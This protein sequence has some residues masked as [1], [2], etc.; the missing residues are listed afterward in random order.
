MGREV[1]AKVDVDSDSFDCLGARLPRDGWRDRIAG[2]YPAQERP[3]DDPTAGKE[4]QT[5]GGPRVL[6]RRARSKVGS[7]LADPS[8]S[9]SHL[10]V[11]RDT[12]W[13]P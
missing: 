4:I 1:I 9:R 2:G 7:G 12:H 11:V 6:L 13:V 8:P 3:V 10:V 5:M